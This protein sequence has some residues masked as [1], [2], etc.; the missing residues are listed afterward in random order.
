ME[1]IRNIRDLGYTLLVVE[2]N[3]RVILGI[4]DRLVV[5]DKGRKIADGIPGE[6]IND[7]GVC[8]AYLGEEYDIT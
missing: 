8:K 6:V 3:M 1:I 2:H 4:S 5:F 7:P